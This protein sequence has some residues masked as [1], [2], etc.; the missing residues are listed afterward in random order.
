MI[1]H[2]RTH[3]PRVI[4]TGDHVAALKKSS[5]DNMGVI[6][7]MN[8]MKDLCEAPTVPHPLLYHVWSLPESS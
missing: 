3:M 4:F 6:L 8:Q 7:K 5:N 2:T 1:T